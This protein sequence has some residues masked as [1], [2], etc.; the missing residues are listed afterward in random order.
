MQKK[1]KK[2]ATLSV[3]PLLVCWGLQY[4]F[5]KFLLLMTDNCY[6]DKI[7]NIKHWHKYIYY[8]CQPMCHQTKALFGQLP[9]RQKLS[10][11][12]TVE[13]PPIR[14]KSRPRGVCLLENCLHFCFILCLSKTA[15][16]PPTQKKTS[17][18]CHLSKSRRGIIPVMKLLNPNY[19]DGVTT[20]KGEFFRVTLDVQQLLTFTRHWPKNDSLTSRDVPPKKGAQVISGMRHRVRERERERARFIG[21]FDS[22][23]P[24]I[25]VRLGHKSRVCVSV[26]GARR[27]GANFPSAWSCNREEDGK[28]VEEKRKTREKEVLMFGWIKFQRERASVLISCRRHRATH[29]HTKPW[30]TSQSHKRGPEWSR[31]ESLKL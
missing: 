4:L 7:L 23:S 6:W 28:T 12:Q 13:K 24:Q 15:D 25:E 20:I 2:N 19:L 8:E 26:Q 11:E 30:V 21:R 9:L 31:F 1:K 29:T 3:H 22:W 14:F 16:V 18:E 17:N 27:A 10:R 5:H